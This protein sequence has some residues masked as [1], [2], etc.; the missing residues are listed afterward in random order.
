VKIIRVPPQH[1]VLT[2]AVG[3]GG[4]RAIFGMM[5]PKSNLKALTEAIERF[6]LDKRTN[7]A[8]FLA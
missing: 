7:P 3:H 4:T 6:V 2:W 1:R 8:P 5:T